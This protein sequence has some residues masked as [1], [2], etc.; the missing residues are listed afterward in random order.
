MC[1]TEHS[2]FSE[3]IQPVD[4]VAAPGGASA[5][6]TKLGRLALQREFTI[7]VFVAA[8]IGFVH[9]AIVDLREWKASATPSAMG[10]APMF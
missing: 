4:T 7:C 8:Q 1:A 3:A 5:P 2:V 9:R 6:T 10:R